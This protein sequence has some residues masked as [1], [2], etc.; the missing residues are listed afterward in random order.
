[1]RRKLQQRDVDDYS[2]VDLFRLWDQLYRQEH[3]L[4]YQG[5]PAR[6]LRCLKS[7]L[8][9]G[10]SPAQVILAMKSH[11]SKASS[12]IAAFTERF[13]SL[14]VKEPYAS[15]YYK[16]DSR[17]REVRDAAWKLFAELQIVDSVSDGYRDE[18]L[19][20]SLKSQLDTLLEN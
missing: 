7:L 16:I 3:S 6:D 17:P 5:F 1:M 10:Y 8:D 13:E 11:L 14:A 15:F 2:A 18:G 9:A 4:S 12:G 19:I 20:S